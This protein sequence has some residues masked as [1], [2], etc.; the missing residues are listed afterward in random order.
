MRSF[1]SFC[2]S[3]ARPLSA[4]E[5]GSESSA[6]ANKGHSVSS[7]VVPIN[8]THLFIKFR[9]IKVFG[10]YGRVFVIVR[11]VHSYIAACRPSDAAMV[12]LTSTFFV[13]LM[14]IPLAFFR[15]CLMISRKCQMWIDMLCG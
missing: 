6:S 11:R 7:N 5:P 4:G 3:D 9:L 15:R 14:H 8:Q 10:I 2:V 1:I 13:M 12:L